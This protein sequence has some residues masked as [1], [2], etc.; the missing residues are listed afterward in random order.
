MVGLNS[1]RPSLRPVFATCSAIIAS[2]KFAI[3]TLEAAGALLWGLV[4]SLRLEHPSKRIVCVDAPT[5][6]H[7]GSHRDMAFPLIVAFDG[8]NELRCNAHSS[9]HV[10]R[11]AHVVSPALAIGAERQARRQQQTIIVTGGLG[12]LG[13]VVVRLLTEQGYRCLVVSRSLRR[14]G[15][16]RVP[17]PHGVR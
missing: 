14:R 11:L 3:G 7:K 8:E 17:L 9:L 6:T 12:S 4:R 1:L 15:R 5:Q 2:D 13:V 10:P 16:A